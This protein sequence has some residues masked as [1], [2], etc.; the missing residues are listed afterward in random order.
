MFGLIFDGLEKLFIK[1][2]GNSAW[3][4]VIDNTNRLLLA[5]HQITSE[6]GSPTSYFSP[7][8]VEF[9]QPLKRGEWNLNRKYDDAIL[10]VLNAQAAKHAGISEDELMEKTGFYLLE[11]LRY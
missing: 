1:E 3:D 5:E 6:H 7:Y 11:Y 9:S 4:T 2:F 10:F 8:D